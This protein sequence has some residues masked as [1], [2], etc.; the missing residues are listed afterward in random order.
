LVEKHDFASGTSSASSKLIHGGLRYLENFE[1][2]LVF[3]A[4]AERAL[5]L[6]A[7]PHLVR[8]L[9]FYFPVY[10]GDPHGKF[11]LNLGL[12]L[13]DMLALF[14]TPKFHRNLSKQAFLAAI[15]FLKAEGLK[16]GVRY[17]DASMW[18]DVMVVHTLRSAVQL[19]AAVGS[20]VEAVSPIMV[21]NASSLGGPQVRGFR[22]RDLEADQE[23]EIRAHRTIVCGGP[24]TDEIGKRISGS[25][26]KWLKP[27]KGIHLVFDHKRIPIPGALVMSHPED[28][29]ISFVIPRK[30]MGAGVVIVGTTDSPSQDP[31]AP[32]ID[33][34]DIRY[35]MAL[36]ERYFPSLQLKTSD[37][38]SAYVGTRPL[39]AGM[40]GAAE[41]AASESAAAPGESGD[42]AA[43]ALQKVSREHHI[44]DGPGGTVFVA[45][46]KYTTHRRMATEI[47]D[48]ALDRWKRAAAEGAAPPPPRGLKKP[49]TEAP[50]FP[51]ALA[52]ASAS[53]RAAGAAEA[54]VTR[55]G[56]A[57]REVEA[58]ARAED[59]AG[60]PAGFPMLEAQLRYAIRQESVMHL[61]DFYFRRVPLFLARADHGEPWIDRLAQVWSEEREA[62]GELAR[63]E[64]AGLRAQIAERLKPLA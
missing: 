45:G 64:A 26:H 48:Y 11:V 6:E 10:Q 33:G 58:M 13:Y 44:G 35:L 25:W 37:I 29:R 16:G 54:L 61:S 63:E 57:A 30:D 12:W 22:V 59:S 34:E 8:P 3:E 40:E 19:G 31:T 56:A 42:T 4:L 9:P 41:A 39:M 2:H 20:Y 5:L 52:P 28:G 47:I 50:V 46:G 49:R 21:G 53:A 60:D 36:L 32:R 1:L 62:G 43:R 27:S 17:Y 23:L 55:Y 15:P 18:D 24:W 51:E 7:V 38:L 14:R